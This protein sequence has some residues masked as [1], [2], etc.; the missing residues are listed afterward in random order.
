MDLG[1][2][3]KIVSILSPSNGSLD[4][5]NGTL[6][7]SVTTKQQAPIVGAK[8]FGSAVLRGSTDAPGCAVFADLPAGNYTRD[9]RR[10]PGPASSTRSAATPM[11]RK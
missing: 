5:N 10:E 4:P 9:G 3:A 11:A 7:I 2:K 1:E 8:V 6:A